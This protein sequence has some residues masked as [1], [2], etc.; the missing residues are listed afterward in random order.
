[1]LH[2]CPAWISLDEDFC[3]KVKKPNFGKSVG[4]LMV[5]QGRNYLVETV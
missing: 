1:M 2:F 3:L 4:N 5:Q